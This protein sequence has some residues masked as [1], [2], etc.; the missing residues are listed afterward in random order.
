M[1][2]LLKSDCLQL[3]GLLDH[4]NHV[5]VF[6]TLYGDLWALLHFPLLLDQFLE[7]LRLP[8]HLGSRSSFNRLLPAVDEVECLGLD[9]F[10]AKHSIFHY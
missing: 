2:P 6:W 10:L 9:V 4:P 3:L 1:P 5:I 8:L 7:C